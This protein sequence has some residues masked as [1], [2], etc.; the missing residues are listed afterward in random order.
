M[1]LPSTLTSFYR[2]KWGPTLLKTLENPVTS[3]LIHQER[4]YLSPTLSDRVAIESDLGQEK[5]GT[6]W[7]RSFHRSKKKRKKKK[8]KATTP[9]GGGQTTHTHTHTQTH[10]QMRQLDA[11]LHNLRDLRS[12][13]AALP[14][15]PTPS[16][17]FWLVLYR[18]FI[19]PNFGPLYR[20]AF[21]FV[22]FSVCVFWMSAVVA[23]S[24]RSMSLELLAS[25]VKFIRVERTT[26]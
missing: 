17:G 18:V 11:N 14:P 21:F 6:I 13:F 25:S 12:G 22:F 15:R 19:L 2:T 8:P 9:S 10:M 26:R 3:S 20:S 24:C 1:P 7:L 16:L 23:L 5:L 4:F